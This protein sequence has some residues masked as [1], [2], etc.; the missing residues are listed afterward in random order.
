MPTDPY[1]KTMN[2]MLIEAFQRV[3]AF[4]Y[5]SVK[6]K[7]VEAFNEILKIL[8]NFEKF[9]SA[10]FFGGSKPGF[11][12]YMIWPWFER[13]SSLKS[14]TNNEIGSDK[15]PR[16]TQ[17]IKRMLDQPAVKETATNEES[18]VE[19]YKTLLSGKE[20]N[21]D[22]GLPGLPEEEEVEIVDVEELKE[23]TIE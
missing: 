18:M 3:A 4:L 2:Q 9:L 6:F 14:L 1:I 17:W 16:L 10:D 19:Y 23:L 7:D 5:K 20:P 21:Y 13:F 8:N 12:D 15:F 11:T 22:L